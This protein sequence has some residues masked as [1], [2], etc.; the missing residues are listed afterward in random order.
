MAH[1]NVGFLA[2]LL[3]LVQALMGLAT[4]ELRVRR[5][6]RWAL[7]RFIGC[8]QSSIEEGTLE[9]LKSSAWC[10]TEAQ[11]LTSLALSCFRCRLA[12]RRA[13]ARASVVMR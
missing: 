6:F 7:P 5:R 10:G 1:A 12:L 8:L 9:A 4:V 13:I 2:V 3:V 11:H